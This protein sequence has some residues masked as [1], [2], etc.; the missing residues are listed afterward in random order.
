DLRYSG[1]NYEIEIAWDGALAALR[2]QF[3]A[4]HRRLYGYATGESVECVNLRVTARAAGR[5]LELPQI[6]PVG[7]LTPLGEQ[8]T[9]FRETG[10][11][12]VSRYSRAAFGRGRSVAGPALIEDDWSTTIVYP[13]QRCHG[14]RFG[15]LILEWS[16]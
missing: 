5:A 12:K 11:P 13:G 3:E 9:S 1:Q 15:N 8:P 2:A 7:A 10:E 4:Q 14:D 6:E 16:S